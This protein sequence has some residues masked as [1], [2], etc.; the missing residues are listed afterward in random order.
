M[1]V[2][3]KSGLLDGERR[4]GNKGESEETREKER[5]GWRDSERWEE[6]RNGRRRDERDDE[7][8]WGGE[9]DV[10]LAERG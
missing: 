1:D 2:G 9:R 6:R 5:E 10:V 8:R 3:S 7:R 4:A